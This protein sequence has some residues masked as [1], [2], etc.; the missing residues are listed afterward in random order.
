MAKEKESDAEILD[1]MVADQESLQRHLY[2]FQMKIAKLG[3]LEEQRD[4]LRGSID[5]LKAQQTELEKQIKAAQAELAT[6]QKQEVE[7]RK[8]TV[9]AEKELADKRQESKALT[10]ACAQ[11]KRMLEAA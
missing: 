11:I 7:T 5:A 3:G 10:N 6:A 2:T 4:N 1:R 8:K 9:E